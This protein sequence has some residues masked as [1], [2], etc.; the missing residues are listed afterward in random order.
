MDEAFNN[1]KLDHFWNQVIE[2][3]LL[4]NYNKNEL[5]QIIVNKINDSF[6]AKYIKYKFKYLQ[7]K[8]ITN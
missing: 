7:L 6:K 8:K 2:K 3:K 4:K 5:P 1:I